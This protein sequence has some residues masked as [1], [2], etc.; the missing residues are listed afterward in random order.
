M[1]LE[2]NIYLCIYCMLIKNKTKVFTKGGERISKSAR[3][4]NLGPP[5]DRK[6]NSGPNGE[7]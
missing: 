4:K 6:K 3:S 7:C 2:Y 5:S 1:L